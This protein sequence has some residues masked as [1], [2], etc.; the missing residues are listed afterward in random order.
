MGC[1]TSGRHPRLWLRCTV[2][3]T[4]TIAT[5]STR[6]LPA[7]MFRQHLGLG[8]FPDTL[9]STR[10][11]ASW[12][13]R[14]LFTLSHSRFSNYTLQGKSPWIPACLNACAEVSGVSYKT[15]GIRSSRKACH[16]NVPLA[17]FEQS[18]S[19]EMLI[20]KDISSFSPEPTSLLLCR[21]SLKNHLTVVLETI[22]S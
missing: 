2:K 15:T 12:I 21:E 5:D 9:N 16:S 20:S 3:S 7:E 6:T 19:F 4:L 11:L 18:D 13:C 22:D 8:N 17:S 14:E 10:F 1:F